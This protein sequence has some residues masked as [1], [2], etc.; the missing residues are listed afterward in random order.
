MKVWKY[1]SDPLWPLVRWIK[2]YWSELSLV[3]VQSSKPRAL[4]FDLEMGRGWQW[5]VDCPEFYIWAGLVPHTVWLVNFLLLLLFVPLHASE[6]L[7]ILLWEMK[8]KCLQT[9]GRLFWWWL[10][11]HGNVDRRLKKKRWSSEQGV[12]VMRVSFYQGCHSIP[13]PVSMLMFQSKE[14]NGWQMHIFF[15][16]SEQTFV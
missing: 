6:P 15:C 7:L 1:A 12:C 10:H 2:C 14:P 13:F 11:I 8:T 9:K 3:N 5:G 4:C 16:I